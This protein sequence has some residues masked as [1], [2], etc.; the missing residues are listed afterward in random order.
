M[1]VN[2]NVS[3]EVVKLVEALERSP[4]VRRLLWAVL[5][6]LLIW[7]PPEL[8]IALVRIKAGIL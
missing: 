3:K 6:C 8:L 2:F 7:L 5:L 1:R 4:S